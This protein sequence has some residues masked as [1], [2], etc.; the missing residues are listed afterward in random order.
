VPSC[1]VD[2]GCRYPSV[3]NFPDQD[4]FL[5]L[6]LGIAECQPDAIN[7]APFSV[8]DQVIEKA[9]LDVMGDG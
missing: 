7:D 3:E 2:L 5:R 9:I 4:L 6:H 1:G 8:L